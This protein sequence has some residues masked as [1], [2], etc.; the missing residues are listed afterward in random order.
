VDAR[1]S[2]T[3]YPEALHEADGHGIGAGVEDDRDTL[4]RTFDRDSDRGGD[5][6]DQ[7]DFLSLEPLATVSTDLRSLLMSRTSRMTCLPSSSPNSL[8]PSRS[9]S[10][11]AQY[12]PPR[13][14][15]PPR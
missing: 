11:A 12:G 10:M 2:P 9:P 4:C 1:E 5:R 15:A 7:V 6:I 14:M 8:R 13:W 3:G